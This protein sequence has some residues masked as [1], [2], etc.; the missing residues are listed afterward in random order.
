MRVGLDA[1]VLKSFDCVLENVLT[2][3]S[4][5]QC[6]S[7]TAAK[8][9][10]LK[11][12]MKSVQRT[13]GHS[14]PLIRDIY[15]SRCKTRATCNL[16]DPIHPEQIS[17]ERKLQC[18]PAKILQTVKQLLPECIQQLLT[19][20]FIMPTLCHQFNCMFYSIFFIIVYTA[21]LFLPYTVMA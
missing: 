5:I 6:G 7:C 3:S 4:M 19:F 14:L 11:R 17:Q 16:S 8:E 12:V 2:S 13:T 18:I 9:E 20:L 15:T 1:N 10:E 21:F